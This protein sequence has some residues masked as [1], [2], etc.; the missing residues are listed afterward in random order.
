MNNEYTFDGVMTRLKTLSGVSNDGQLA[1]KIG[2]SGSAYANLKKRD[3]LPYEKIIALAIT[4][5]VNLHWLFTGESEP[6]INKMAFTASFA[7][8]TNQQ[9]IISLLI[10]LT[11]R[12]LN[13]V[14][15][16]LEDFHVLN[17]LLSQYELLE[18]QVNAQKTSD[19]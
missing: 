13:Q 17:R 12:Q 19:R 18:Q 1:E 11:E 2:L 15:G 7:Q 10:G 8:D 6:Y 14:E 4:Y 9:K 16:A 5:K 3:S